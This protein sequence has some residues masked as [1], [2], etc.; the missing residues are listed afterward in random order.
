[1]LAQG[2][3]AT[4]TSMSSALHLRRGLEMQRIMMI[5]SD[6]HAGPTPDKYVEYLE[7]DYLGDLDEYLREHT[8]RL[9]EF[10]TR[11][12]TGA[13]AEA[14]MRDF[15]TRAL[16]ATSLE[17]RIEPSEADGFVGEII[18]PDGTYHNDIPFT[19]I[20]GGVTD[21]PIDLQCA[22]LRAYNRWLGEHCLPGRQIGLA[23]VPV[24]DVDYAVE[25]VKG[26][27][28]LGLGGVMVIFDG[29][30]GRPLSD[31]SLDPFWA[32]CAEER[33][34]VNFH[35]GSGVPVGM[36]DFSSSDGHFA[37]ATELQFWAR[38]PLWHLI[39]GGVLDRHPDLRIAFVETFADWMPRVLAHMDWQY[40][41]AN[42]AARPIQRK[43]SDCWRAQCFVGAHTASVGEW[44]L[45]Y[46][47]GVA[48]MTYGTDF[49]HSGSP[50]GV[51]DSFLQATMGAADVSEAEARA[52]LGENTARFY[53]MDVSA[54]APIVER[55]GPRPEDILQPATYAAIAE[56][57]E[58][59]QSK[60]RRP[61][62]A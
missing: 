12:G 42:P 2:M 11:L 1:M 48:N 33:L 52:I 50:W 59:L 4:S 53:G 24:H 54:L 8:S 5:S 44:S 15:E 3:T 51:S 56:M 27:R 28:A 55:V 30:N 20:F 38:R 35:A 21:D 17:S 19:G 60:V 23:L 49:P 14:M 10:R 16:F 58:Y 41:N 18:F 32:A 62:S 31:A 13:Q 7:A 36:Y 6:C 37:M 46:D 29:V 26:A 40:G 43:P 39:W 61:D 57:P 9:D 47:I 45:R 22:C 34:P 25:Q